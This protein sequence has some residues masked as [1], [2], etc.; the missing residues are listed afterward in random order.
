MKFN[1]ILI[2]DKFLK[3]KARGLTTFPKNLAT[4]VIEFINEIQFK[5][6]LIFFTY[7][8]GMAAMELHHTLFVQFWAKRRNGL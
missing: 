3:E 7:K 4:Q 8:K 6:K 2:R 5:S 1:S